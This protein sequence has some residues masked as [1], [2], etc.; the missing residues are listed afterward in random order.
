MGPCFSQKAILDSNSPGEFYKDLPI[1]EEILKPLKTTLY[2]I[3][4]K[5]R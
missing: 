4:R 5:P 1:K 2:N 3:L